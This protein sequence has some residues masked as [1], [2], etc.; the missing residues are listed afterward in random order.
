MLTDTMHFPTPRSICR[1]WRSFS[2]RSLLPTGNRRRGTPIKE[3]AI[4]SLMPHSIPRRFAIGDMKIMEKRIKKCD[5]HGQTAPL[6]ELGVAMLGSQAK[7]I[8]SCCLSCN[9]NCY[10]YDTTTELVEQDYSWTNWN[11]RDGTMHTAID[12]AQKWQKIFFFFADAGNSQ[13]LIY[14]I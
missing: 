11:Q 14:K 12:L 7:A 1:R 9:L 10:R 5:S 13:T 3:C 4:A 6:S 8:T 2:T